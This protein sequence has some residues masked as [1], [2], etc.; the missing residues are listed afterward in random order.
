ML[1]ALTLP[2]SQ[3]PAGRGGITKDDGVWTRVNTALKDFKPK[4]LL[5]V[6]EAMNAYCPGMLGFSGVGQISVAGLSE[7]MAKFPETRK[8]GEFD[9]LALTFPHIVEKALGLT[10]LCRASLEHNAGWY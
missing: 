5:Q 7:M 1:P 8:G 10:E 9:F 2:C 6:R 4:T 3:L